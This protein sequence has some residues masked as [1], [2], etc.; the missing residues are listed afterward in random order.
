MKPMAKNT[1]HKKAESVAETLCSFSGFLCNIVISVYMIVILMV[2][3]LY[4]KG[5]AR[6]GT[7][8]E[9]FFLKTMTYGAKTLLPVFLLWLLFRL[10][11]A[12]QKKELPKFTEWPAGLWKNLSVTDRFAVFYGIAVL[13]SYLFTNYREEALWGTASWRMGMWTQLGAVIV[14]FMISRMWQWK[15]WI[16]ALIL[17]VSAVVFSLGYVNKFCLLPVDPE[18]VTPSF[19]STIGNINWY[20]GY[21]VTILF[22][23]VYLL[24]RM[25][26]KMTW[27]KLLLMAYVTI[28]FAS[29]ATQGSSSGIVTFAV[30]MFV[31]FGMSVKDSARMEVFWQEMTMFSAACLITCVLRRLNIF[32]R[33]LILE[34]ITDLLTFSIAGIFMTIMSGIILYW[35]HR[36]RVRRSYPEKMLHRIYCGI[37]IAVPVMILL[38]LLL[39]LIN[40]LAGGALTPNITDPEVTKWLTFNAGWGSAR[41]GTWAAGAR[42]FWEADFLHKIFGV[43][44]DCLYAFLSNEGSVELQTMVNDRFGGNRLT[45][46]HNEW[47]TVLVDIGV[48]GLV[49]YAGMMITAIRDF[50]RAGENRMLVGACGIC[51]LAYTV[52]NMFSFQQVMNISTVFVIMGIGE[53]LR[54]APERCV[55]A[56]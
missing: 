53:N 31:L 30:V 21:L 46:A 22:G 11:T 40:T 6:I 13:V 18:Y 34:G 38:V 12:V 7:E 51:V 17:P 24:W 52:N 9:T 50:L 44:P 10:V 26:E 19:I 45:N 23:G 15:S 14:Y 36:T 27:K 5:Y 47:L 39:T 3:P 4:N 37:A 35:I 54:S 33:E 29:L 49:S 42:C 1:K 56:S 2:L 8:K 55:R 28:G 20:C 43:G 48:L 16:P 25:E 32:S 41:G